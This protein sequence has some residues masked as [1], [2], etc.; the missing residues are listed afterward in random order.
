MGLFPSLQRLIITGCDPVS[1]EQFSM[2]EGLRTLT[3]EDSGFSDLSG[4]ESL[5]LLSVSFPR[6]CVKDL[7]SL[8]GI[9]HLLQVDVTGN[10]LSDHSFHQIIPAL[11]ESG[12]RVTASEE[13]EWKLTVRLHSA[14]VRISCYRD[15]Q[16]Q[17]YKLFRPGLGLTDAPQYAHPLVSAGDIRALLTGDPSAAHRYFDG[18]PRLV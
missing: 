8:L 11:R 13:L 10:P 2:L 5:P 9:P 12:C 15:P 4:I 3:L 7:R 1:V 14:G 6:N 16:G 18:E 17:G